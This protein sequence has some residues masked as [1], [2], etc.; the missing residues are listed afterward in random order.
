MIICLICGMEINKQNALINK[1]AM[2]EANSTGH[3]ITCPFCGAPLAF[4]KEEYKDL[5]PENL[6]D[7]ETVI[8]DH[9]M[10]LEVFNG[11]FYKEAAVLAESKNVSEMFKALSNIEM[12]HANIHR[13][14]IGDKSLP[15]LLK[16]DYSK[17]KNDV[18][19]MDEAGVREEHA[20]SYY[21]KYMNIIRDKNVKLIFKTL[22]EIESQHITLLSN[23]IQN[24]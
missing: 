3:I 23:N 21:K 13:K 24:E 6:T 16:M 15:S 8:L 14:L 20:V 10:K 5:Y 4:L 9:A 2:L 19:L 17:Y 12:M 1:S 11:D 18:M 7:E 22:S